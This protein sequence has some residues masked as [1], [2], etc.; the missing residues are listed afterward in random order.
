[1][2]KLTVITINYNNKSGLQKTLSNFLALESGCDFEHVI[3]DGGSTDGSLELIKHHVESCDFACYISEPD[4]GIYNAMNK[5]LHLATGDYIA[6]LNSGDSFGTDLDVKFFC[7]LINRYHAT[8]GIYGNV[9]FYGLDGTLERVWRSGKAKRWKFLYGW[10]PPHPMLMIKK[11]LF[12]QYGG[13]DEAFKLASDYDLIL[14]LFFRKK[15]TLVFV[16]ETFVNMENGG[17]SNGSI[18]NVL[19]ANYEVLL[20]WRKYYSLL[21]PIWLIAT[22]PISKLLQLKHTRR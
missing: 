18:K 22:K 8:D 9:N 17:I 13:F 5:G 6:F 15:R 2:M 21:I 16:D 7:K 12:K 11:E 10:M 14:R 1:M 4:D 19:K 3:I 20:A